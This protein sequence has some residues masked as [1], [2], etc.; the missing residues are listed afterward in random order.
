[1]VYP[2]VPIL[3]EVIGNAEDQDAQKNGTQE[4]NVVLMRKQNRKYLQTEPGKERREK[5]LGDSK[6]R[7]IE[8]FSFRVHSWP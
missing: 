7:K 3:R 4:K 5:E 2:V 8:R 6:A 1:M